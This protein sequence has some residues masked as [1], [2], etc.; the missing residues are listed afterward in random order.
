MK[1]LKY[2][3]FL[4]LSFLSF[5]Q[6]KVEHTFIVETDTFVLDTHF[7]IKNSFQ[8][9]CEK[10][11][12]QLRLQPN[13]LI[14]DTS[15]LG[16]TLTY[17]YK[18]FNPNI[19]LYDTEIYT[20]RLEKEKIN[21]F[22]ANI[23]NPL[24]QSKA[25]NNNF[26]G[27]NK[28]GALS[29]GISFGNQQGTNINSQFNLELT[30][31]ISTDLW[32]KAK[33]NDDNIPIQ[34]SGN[35]T[36]LRNFDQIYIQVFNN[37]HTLL[38]GDC[39][40][41]PQINS[42]Y[43][44]FNKK[45]TGIFYNYTDTLKN[46]HKVFSGINIASN[47]GIFSK[48]IFDAQE[49]NNGPYFLK[50][51][52]N[53]V[54]II[55]LA[56]TERV[57][58]NGKQLKRGSENDYTIDYN[59]GQI[60]FNLK[61][62]LTKFDRI[63][64]DFEY[65]NQQFA[66]STTYAYGGFQTSF[67]KSSISFY[68]EKD[69]KNNPTI[70]LNN[71]LIK[72]LQTLGDAATETSILNINP[73]K[74]DQ[75]VISYILKDT[76][77]N[78]QV[79]DSILEYNQ[80]PNMNHYTVIFSF[81]GPNK[82][83]YRIK[84]NLVNGKIYQWVPPLSNLS[85][86]DYI[87]TTQLIP[88]VLQRMINIKNDVQYK[89]WILKTEI[90]ITQKDVNTFSKKNKEN[91]WGLALKTDLS[92][93]KNVIIEGDTAKIISSL[94]FENL[95]KKFSTL[96]AI[97]TTE[98][99][100]DWGLTQSTLNFINKNEGTI[101]INNSIT[102][103]KWYNNI[104][105]SQMHYLDTFVG[106]KTGTEI[107]Y[108]DSNKFVFS[109]KPNYI[110]GKTF[111]LNK[112]L[113][114]QISKL[115]IP[116]NSHLSILFNDDYRN[117]NELIR[118]SYYDK[119][120]K[121]LQT[122]QRY[123][124]LIGFQNRTDKSGLDTAF[125]KRSYVN[126][127][128]FKMHYDN[129]TTFKIDWQG[130]LRDF[131]NLE[132]NTNEKSWQNLL[133]YHLNNK[134][135]SIRLSGN[136]NINT[137]NEPQKNLIY[138]QVAT[139]QGTHTWIDYNKNG[140]QE[141]NEFET[142]IYIYQANFLPYYAPSNTTFRIINKNWQQQFTFDFSN[143]KHWIRLFE[144]N[145][146]LNFSQKQ[147]NTDVLKHLTPR[148]RDDSTQIFNGTSLSNWLYFNKKSPKYTLSFGMDNY[149]YKNL[150]NSG[151]EFKEKVIYSFIPAFNFN[152]NWSSNSLFTLFN[153]KR[154]LQISSI[155]NYTL[156]GYGLGEDINY[157]ASKKLTLKWSYLYQN[158]TNILGLERSKHHQF[159]FQFTFKSLPKYD[160]YLN[161][162]FHNIAFVGANTSP[163]AFEMLQSLNPGNNLTW[164]IA[165]TNYLMQNLQLIFNYEGRLVQKSTPY[166][167]LNTQIKLIF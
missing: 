134:N 29:R 49:G 71:A 30:G 58:L 135:K 69:N 82:G 133:N 50:G 118:Q 20:Y 11:L 121:L 153:Q 44:I 70:D 57:F 25:L 65:S 101:S 79:F 9:N 145:S 124:L 93:Q 7:I 1:H 40:L 100:R 13:R 113:Y 157:A 84:N 28:K 140:L 61:Y 111:N 56:N 41:H 90:A 33:I 36:D 106:Y 117:S 161:T 5:A 83:N 37:Q 38:F 23:I 77:V 136:Y 68:G 18:I 66:K 99:Y 35:T 103:K 10:Q 12:Y 107:A 95:N 78:A 165:I 92:H 62:L 73:T 114:Q 156:T 45:L 17:R 115:Q 51:V 46:N 31:K 125:K 3:I 97:R 110:I 146:Q 142:A 14:L 160:I 112:R 96:Q 94:N 138:T 55:V 143:F 76:V 158:Q 164:K 26:E 141:I 162:T 137:A 52:N 167:W 127:Y 119:S 21:P 159:T 80:D 155:N 128:E 126:N 166:H 149:K 6:S 139:G 53:E 64:I 148:L 47:K 98:Y 163:V 151:F 122:Y 154:Y 116:L 24:E 59:T 39:F 120:I 105:L 102:Y 2:L 32:L 8:I 91:D 89:N 27:L 130:Q 22:L 60:F 48:N 81:V 42:N 43:L 15:L 109:F 72:N 19:T 16:D 34:P 63:L 152:T 129:T 67:L 54:Y 86:G 75:E 131:N 85:Q 108:I 150:I 123:S 88:P 4:L 132:T 104:V 147:K 144:I 74:Y 87:A